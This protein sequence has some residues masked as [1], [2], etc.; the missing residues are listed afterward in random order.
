MQSPFS[1]N[2]SVG[3]ELKSLVCRRRGR[4]CC[5]QLHMDPG[6]CYIRA[7]VCAQ[8]L[9]QALWAACHKKRLMISVRGRVSEPLLSKHRPRL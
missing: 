1:M 9:Q 8:G 3:E 4:L 5:S 2:G 7:F 6:R